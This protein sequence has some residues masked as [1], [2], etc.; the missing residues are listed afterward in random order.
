MLVL[1]QFLQ[2]VKRWNPLD[3][4][5]IGLESIVEQILQLNVLS[6]K[7]FKLQSWQNLEIRGGFILLI[8]TGVS[9]VFQPFF[10]LKKL[11]D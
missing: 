7:Y 9:L 10:C 3:E 8:L 11:M 1:R 4:Q 2:R 6:K 5:D